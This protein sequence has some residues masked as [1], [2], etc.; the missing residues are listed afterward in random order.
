MAGTT[1][2]HYRDPLAPKPN[3]GVTLGVSALIER[4]DAILLERRRDNGQWG[5]IGGGVEI[6]ESLDQAL[7]REVLEE[8]GL[9]VASYTFFGTF[10][11]PS[12]IGR[13]SNGNVVRF[14]VIVYRVEVE[15]F[16]TL[17]CSDESFELGFF[18]R[19]E[20]ADLDVVATGRDVLDA[21]LTR[22]PPVLD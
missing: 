13:F 2:F 4:D 21:Y 18:S 5:L 22:Q 7:R 15:D 12:R 10:S 1:T 17:A 14:V 20:I 16:T 6:D 8:T 3:R 11:D 19:A 9:T